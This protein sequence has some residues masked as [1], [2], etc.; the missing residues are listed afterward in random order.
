ML[1]FLN[2]SSNTLSGFPSYFS[3]S[4]NVE[5]LD[6]RYNRFMGSLDWILDLYHIKLLLLGGNM[7]EGISL[8][9]SVIS[10]T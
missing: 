5:V 2:M 8:Q 6:I 10:S 1:Y 3:S 9:N 4:S 7:F